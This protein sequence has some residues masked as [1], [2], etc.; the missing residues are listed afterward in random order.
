MR[1]EID[2]S[3]Y[4]TNVYFNCHS[5]TCTAYVLVEDG[6]KGTIPDGYETLEEWAEN[7]NIR[8]YKIVDGNLEFD[9]NRDEILQTQYEKE[10]EDNRYVCHKEI[11]NLTNLVKSDNADT[12][13]TSTS[14]LSNLIEVTDSNKFASTYIELL[15][16]ENISNKLHIKFNNGNLLTNSATSKKD[17]GISFEVNAD[18]TINIK[19]TATN[20]IEYDIGGYPNNTKPILAFKRGINYYLSS[21]GHQ[22]KMYNYDGVDREEIY[23]GNGGV[24]N[25]TDGDRKVTEIVLF[26]PNET[27]IKTTIKPM[28]NIGDT[29]KEYI[30]YEGNDAVVYLDGNTFTPKDIITIEDGTPILRGIQYP[31]ST[32]QARIGLK[33]SETLTPSATLTPSK[34]RIATTAL[35]PSNETY[36]G[37]TNE[38]YLYDINMPI[39]YL[40]L[41]YMYCMEDI[42]LKVIYPNSKKNNDLTGYETPNGGFAIDEEGNMYCN[43]ATIRGSAIVNGDAFSVDEGGNMKANSGE[44][45]GWKIDETGL[46]N[47]DKFVNNNGYSNIYTV[48]D[49]FMIRMIMSGEWTP[50]QEVLDHYDLNN[51][52]VVDVSDL[53][54]LTAWVMGK[55]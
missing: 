52:G 37:Y 1:Y 4:I 22:I 38:K 15:T 16:N 45:G 54:I 40:D 55:R 46:T 32:E 6:G 35:Y 27:K 19:G 25:F 31:S 18:R 14:I 47:N 20:D 23:S 7:A 21:N 50:T 3:G 24:I 11:S 41:T 36:V 49:I 12:Y 51:D 43:N 42:K 39:T 2:E 10:H 13:L 29:A 34:E 5:G 30:T 53:A 8:A 17:S 44:I 28:L 48:A 9:A 33:P 26:I